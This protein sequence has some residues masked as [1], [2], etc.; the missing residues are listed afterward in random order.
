M[1]CVNSVEQFRSNVNHKVILSDWKNCSIL[2]NPSISNS[3]M[4]RQKN[5]AALNRGEDIDE[6]DVV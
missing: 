3:E 1:L 2:K 4:L 5:I 6:S